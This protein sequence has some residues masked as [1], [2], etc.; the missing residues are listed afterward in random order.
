MRILRAQMKSS[1]PK[2]GAAQVAADLFAMADAD[3]LAAA[4]A[5]EDALV[6][7]R[8]SACGLPQDDRRIGLALSGG[9]IRSATFSL[10]ILQA[11]SRLR[12][13]RHVDYLSTVSG[14]SYIGSFF[15]ALYVEPAMRGV[16]DPDLPDE[17]ARADFVERPLGSPRGRKAVS[18]LREFGRYLTPG[19]FSDTMYGASLMARNW[20]SLQLV[21]GILPLLFFVAL[22]WAKAALGT[23]SEGF[24]ALQAFLPILQFPVSWVLVSL[25]VLCAIA[26]VSLSIGFWFSRREQVSPSV[27]RRLATNA[28]FLIGAAAAVFLADRYWGTLFRAVNCGSSGDSARQACPGLKTALT[29]GFVPSLL[30]L[31][32]AVAAIAYLVYLARASCELGSGL[33]GATPDEAEERVRGRFTR[34]LATS[35]LLLCVL[36]AML[37]V[38]AIGYHVATATLHLTESVG[39][40]TNRA[41]ESEVYA[42]VR[43][44]LASFWPFIAV[45]APSVLTVW[46]HGALRHGSGP[47]WLSRPTGQAALGLSIMFLWLVIWSATSWTISGWSD[48]SGQID[49]PDS[50]PVL[51]IV[52]VCLAAALAIQSFCFGF[53]NLSSLVSLYASRLKRAYIGASN[54]YE[55]TQGFDVERLGD[56]IAMPAYYGLS[57]AAG[58]PPLA[59]KSLFCLNH[60]RPVHLINV[61]IA[62]TEPEGSSRIVAY[63]RKG[64]LM[65]VSPAG[66]LFSSGSKLILRRFSSAE[67]LPLS[68]WTAIS[69]AA[70]S[71][72][73]GSL[74]SFGLS[75]LAMMAN[76]RLGYWWRQDEARRLTVRSAEDT[77][78]GYLFNELQAR[79]NSDADR[80]RWY[81][82]DGGHFENTGAYAL[83]QRKL[84]FIIVCDNGADP[85]YR[86]DDVVRLIDRARIDLETEIQFLGSRDL[87]ML[88]GAQ[89]PLRSAFGTYRE[90]ASVP[91]P[92]GTGPMPYATL[93]RLRYD[94][95]TI[96]YP[97]YV[98]G[99]IDPGAPGPLLLLI[100]PRLNFTEP[101]ELLAYQRSETGGAFPQQTTLD[102][103]FDEEQ[104]ESYR[105]FGEVVGLRI[106]EA[107]GSPWTP[108]GHV[109]TPA[110]APPGGKSADAAAP[111]TAQGDA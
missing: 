9:G 57:G 102:Q 58:N 111:A 42:A 87:D 103:F 24:P 31:T 3:G 95:D 99:T 109:A 41:R 7:L 11:L 81:L 104:W 56:N 72:A 73:I 107:A 51:G 49:G 65:Q 21:L 16:V 32:L 5:G 15:G 19:G 90:L 47:G 93:A 43:I 88:L 98:D 48:S 86:L 22:R 36:V 28:P 40:I 27:V 91:V 62:Q 50:A 60:A 77:V 44:G 74:T 6:A 101:P 66:L 52:F 33:I 68:L 108:H 29:D 55:A 94:I 105:R 12:L 79:F 75:I 38:D 18:R 61:T 64:K 100:K 80:T 96:D 26:S 39:H 59:G 78:P 25:I 63:D 46:A 70:A 4:L 85:D 13:L 83:I 14:G 53:L 35:N 69:G 20:V 2:G 97:T 8:R 45:V 17:A 84:D 82:T 92:H 34:A 89:G 54:P 10:G 67:Q 30:A 1:R 76:V 23:W 71:T 110:P 37:A 106:F